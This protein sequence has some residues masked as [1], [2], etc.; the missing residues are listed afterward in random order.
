ML[1][2]TMKRERR[3]SNHDRSNQLAVTKGNI[4][5]KYSQNATKIDLGNSIIKN[6]LLQ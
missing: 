6:I 3:R 4:M 1:N 2:S 5:Q